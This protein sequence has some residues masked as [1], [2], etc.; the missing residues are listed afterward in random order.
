[1]Q[2]LFFKQD[3]VPLHWQL[4]SCAPAPEFGGQFRASNT[5]VL[6]AKFDT[7]DYKQVIPA[8]LELAP[9]INELIAHGSEIPF[10]EYVEI[11]VKSHH[12]LTVIHPFGDGNGRTLRAFFNLLL[13]RRGLLP[14][15]IKVENKTEYT[16]TLSQADMDGTFDKL[17]AVIAKAILRAQAELSETP[18]LYSNNS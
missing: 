4:F 15:Y 8:L 13:M 11:L 6:G 7:I 18:P 1:M 14:I 3:L 2:Y 17:Y 12:R 5:L 16:D 9:T 10:S